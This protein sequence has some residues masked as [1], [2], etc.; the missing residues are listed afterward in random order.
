[1]L[2]GC[3]ASACMA[4]PQ[5]CEP[6][7]RVLILCTSNAPYN[8]DKPKD[9]TSVLFF[10]TCFAHYTICL[11]FLLP[12]PIIRPHA[13]HVLCFHRMF[14]DF[15]SKIIFVPLP[16]YPSRQ[17][18]WASQLQKTG[19]KCADPDEVRLSNAPSIGRLPRTNIRQREVTFENSKLK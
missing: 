5:T 3:A 1:M 11:A 19:I 4:W 8:V 16:N 10:Q 17:I 15:F 7:D 9:Y 14:N 12:P 13:I 18:L 6:E 2:C